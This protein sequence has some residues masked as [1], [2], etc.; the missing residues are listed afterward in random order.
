MGHYP[1][2]QIRTASHLFVATPEVVW[3]AVRHDVPEAHFQDSAIY[4]YYPEEIRLFSAI[5]LTA[6]DPWTNGR[7]VVFPWLRA[8]LDCGSLPPFSKPIFA[9]ICNGRAKWLMK[10]ALSCDYQVFPLREYSLGEQGSEQ[11]VL[12]LLDAIDVKDELLLAG[13]SRFL[14]AQRLVVMGSF[15]EEA[16]LFG[17]LSLEAGLEYMRQCL[18]KGKSEASFSDVYEVISNDFPGGEE[19]ARWFRRMYDNRVILVHPSSR[20]GDYRTAP[21][22]QLDCRRLLEWLI[23]LYRYILLGQVPEADGH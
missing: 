9:N 5:S 19:I 8:G 20:M 21:I 13:L 15:F 14:S 17:L 6:G 22:L 23:L 3:C 7:F 12:E 16:S 1:S 18:R 11:E 4:T 10:S 2:Y